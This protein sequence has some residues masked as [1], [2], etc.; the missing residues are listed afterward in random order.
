MNT[1]SVASTISLAVILAIPVFV[2]ADVKKEEKTLVTFTG[3]LG[4]IANLFGGKAAKEGITS[5][6][7]VSGDRK[8]TTNE[9]RGEIVDLREQKIYELD[10]RRK[11]Y[12]VTTFEELRQR[13][14]EMEQKAKADAAKAPKDEQPQHEG[15]EMDVD[16]DVKNT[17]QT[18]TLNG[19]QAS[20]VIV[21]VTVREKGKKL[22][23]SGGLVMTADNWMTK[24]V[25]A[26]KEITDFDI[27]YYKALMTPQLTADAQQMATAFAMMPGLKDAMARMQRAGLEGTAI[28]TTTTVEAVKSPEQMKQQEQPAADSGGGIPTSVGGALGGLMKRRAQQNQQ[29]ASASPRSTFMTTTNEILKIATDATATDV[30]MP[31]GFKETK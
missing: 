3:M 9:M 5:M 20:Q 14:T 28:S 24:S 31:A 26:L 4:K 25:P 16:L 10:M 27:R 6:V 11:T 29:N 1:K 17:G 15:K 19:F 30:A 12:K 8:M 18:R 2:Q 23:E 22:E 21:T 7:A 13:L